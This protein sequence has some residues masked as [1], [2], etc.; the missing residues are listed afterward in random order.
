M[1]NVKGTVL[2]PFSYKGEQYKEGDEISINAIHAAKYERLNYV[3]LDR[4]AEKKVEA[5]IEKEKKG[6]AG[7]N[8]PK[9]KN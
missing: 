5:A 6:N 1:A 7:P 4:E 8:A 9:T 3:K 2:Q